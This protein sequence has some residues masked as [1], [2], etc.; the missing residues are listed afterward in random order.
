VKITII[1]TIPFAYDIDFPLHHPL[2]A[3][4]SAICYLSKELQSRGHQVTV[5]NAS[6]EPSDKHGV[7]VRPNPDLRDAAEHLNGQDV[8]IVAS[9]ACGAHLRG[10]GIKAPL[11]LWTQHAHDQPAIQNLHK[12]VER[13]SWDAIVY[14]SDWQ[15]KHYEHVFAMPPDKAKIIRNGISPAFETVERRLPFY[16]DDR[17]P[18]LA[19]TSTPFRGLQTLLSAFPRIREAIPGAWLFVFSSMKVYQKTEDQDDFWCFY[20]LCR[21][22]DGVRYEGS[23]GQ[24][25]LA[26]ALSKCDVLA[27]PSIF[28]EGQ[29]VAIGEA[30]AAGCAVFTTTLGALPEVYGDLATM[31]RWDGESL[32][33]RYADDVIAGIKAMRENPQEALAQRQ[34]RIDFVHKNFLW[35]NIA[36]QWETWLT[37][38]VRRSTATAT[39]KIAS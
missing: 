2:G 26:C 17:P 1:D 34:R 36:E 31:T 14:V 9:G 35:K 13:Y 25:D 32:V 29:C 28:S 11:V 30:M 15:R 19:Y 18:V 4:N 3:G 27:Y 33:R 12:P 10:A 38:L 20:E 6:K 7:A 21:L 8:C 22:M 16:N 23:L 37:E 39:Q 24:Q 5:F